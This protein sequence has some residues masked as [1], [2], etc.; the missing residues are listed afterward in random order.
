MGSLVRKDPSNC[1]S[2]KI[3]WEQKEYWIFITAS[4]SKLTNSNYYGFWWKSGCCFLHF[5]HP[6]PS[7]T[8]PS[9]RGQH[10]GGARSVFVNT[11]YFIELFITDSII[12]WERKQ[13]VRTSPVTA[14]HRGD[15]EASENFFWF[16]CKFLLPSNLQPLVTFLHPY[17]S[18]AHCKHKRRLLLMLLW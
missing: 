8:W 12:D 18:I 3:R 4:M 10:R 16:I 7:Q 11:D 2:L 9:V 5:P 17:L 1:P 6:T 13:I 15:S 14:A